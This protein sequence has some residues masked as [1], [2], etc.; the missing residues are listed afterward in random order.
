[1]KIIDRIRKLLYTTRIETAEKVIYLTFDDGPEPDATEFVLEQLQSYGAK[2]TFFCCGYNIERYPKLFIR[3]KHDGHTVASHTMKHL[4][5]TKTPLIHY[6]KDI[7]KFRKAYH[8]SVIR[9]PYGSLTRLQKILLPIL[10]FKVVLWSDDSTD[11]YNEEEI[12]TNMLNIFIS[13]VSSGSIIL[14]HFCKKHEKRTRKILPIFLK[15]MC[16]KGY[17]FNC[18]KEDLL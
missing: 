16:D 10:G 12:N 13:N 8:T 18:I 6:I 9:P 4:K 3:L 17:H 1:M 7:C 5:G 2:A 11:W 15:S 14:F